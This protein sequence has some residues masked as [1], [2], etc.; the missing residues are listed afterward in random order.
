[1]RA[2]HKGVRTSSKHPSTL[3]SVSLAFQGLGLSEQGFP[4]YC[5]LSHSFMMSPSTGAARVLKILLFSSL[6]CQITCSQEQ[7]NPLGWCSHSE[8]S[9]VC[10]APGWAQSHPPASRG[11]WEALQGGKYRESYQYRDTESTQSC[12]LCRGVRFWS[13]LKLYF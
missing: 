9:P 10:K 13:W 7:A 4:L 5:I 1:M 3:N 2:E 6:C 12:L 8:Y 11:S